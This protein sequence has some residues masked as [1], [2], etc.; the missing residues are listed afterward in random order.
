LKGLLR[1]LIILALAALM[2]GLPLWLLPAVGTPVA[3]PHVQ[4]PAEPLTE[5]PLF[6]L[7]GQPYQITNTLVTTVLADIVLL[8]LAVIAGSAA[9]RRL[10]RREADP[11]ARDKEGDDLMVPKRWHNTFEALLEY[12]YDLVEQVVGDKRALQVF[13]LIATIFLFVL[14]ANW[15]H[16]VPGVDSVGIVHCADPGAGVKGFSA[17]RMGDSDIYRLD[18]NGGAIPR[19][20]ELAATVC[21]EH[22]SAGHE[23]EG[24][25]A[26]DEAGLRYVVTPFLR[27]ATTDLNLTLGIALVAMAAVQIFG[28]G[29]LGLSYFAKFINLPALEEGG[30][31]YILFGTGFIEIISE[32]AKVVSFSL[33][34]FGNLFAGTILLFVM[35]FLIPIGVPII[36]YLLEV[37]V[38]LIQA[39]VFA[40]LSLVFVALAMTGHGDDHH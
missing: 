5:T 30:L 22:R 15:L 7:A 16:F 34:L 37:F 27:T 36:F 21:P 33:R 3:F 2:C 11:Q 14:V 29:E 35:A 8:V 25:E 13:P 6:T 32:V 20:G 38:G 10:K 40:M 18:F 39:F 12:L 17:V 23:G 4:M 24:D 1:L 31:G 9:R 19:V 26:G 28:V